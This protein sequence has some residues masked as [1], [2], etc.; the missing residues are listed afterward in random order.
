MEQAL[1]GGL[2]W[3][4]FNS[5]K[6]MGELQD[7]TQQLKKCIEELEAEKTHAEQGEIG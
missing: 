7:E 6:I 2:P 1:E 4:K 5:L 3:L